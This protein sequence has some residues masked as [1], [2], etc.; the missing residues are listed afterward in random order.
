MSFHLKIHTTVIYID[1]LQTSL[2]NSGISHL[3]LPLT[4]EHSSSENCFEINY[5]RKSRAA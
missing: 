5:V 1:T 3:Y 2:V 4:E